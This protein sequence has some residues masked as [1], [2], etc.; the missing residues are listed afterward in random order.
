MTPL[1]L[2]WLLE[3]AT[4]SGVSIVFA[5]ALLWWVLAQQTTAMERLL[6][7]QASLALAI[8]RLAV[9]VD[10]TCGTPTPIR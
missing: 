8:E 6:S 7:N 1:S 10:L 9:R 4:R 2:P 3:W 5:C